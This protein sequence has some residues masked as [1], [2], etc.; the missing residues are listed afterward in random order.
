M[1]TFPFTN[2]SGGVAA[3]PAMTIK[4]INSS[5]DFDLRSFGTV[6]YF[7]DWDD[8]NDETSNLNVL[9]H[10]YAN[11]TYYIEVEPTGSYRPYYNNTGVDA[12]QV[13]IVDVKAGFDFGAS[14]NKGFYGCVNMSDFDCVFSAS[15]NVLDFDTCW[16]NCSLL[17]SFPV[18]DTSA[19]TDFYLTWYNC[20]GLT[21]FPA[22]DMSSATTVSYAWWECSSMTSIGLSDFSSCIN[23]VGSWGNCDVLATVPANMFDNTGTLN[24][25]AFS[26]A[27][28]ACALTAQSIENILVS[29]DTNGASGITL[30]ISGGTNAAKTTWSTAATTA[31]D[32]LIVKSWSIAYNA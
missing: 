9:T 30:T 21:S 11:G 12:E 7:V 15:S 14:I 10:T 4:I 1:F 29:L 5:A 23:F 18:I 26:T 17:S 22:L 20:N 8:G 6:D 27:F 28:T 25:N 32:N 13:R 3:T 2:F 31:Y 24:T 19:G 16:R